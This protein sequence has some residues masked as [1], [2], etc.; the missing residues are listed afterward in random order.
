MRILVGTIGQS[1]LASDDGEKWERLG[2]RT[3]FHS[4]G[5]VR[6]LMSDPADPAI[7]LAGTDQGIL[8]SADGGRCWERLGGVLADKTVWRIASH[9]TDKNVIFAGTGTPSVPGLYR[10]ED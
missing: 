9:P 2:P 10:T 6:T 4:D 8:R 5:I 7:L 3:G 1:I